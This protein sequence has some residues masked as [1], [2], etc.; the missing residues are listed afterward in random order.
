MEALTEQEYAPEPVADIRARNGFINVMGNLTLLTQA[1]NSTVSD[2]PFTVKV[3][4]VKA[5]SALALNRELG[6][7]DRRDESAIQ[8]RS[9]ALFE[10]ARDIWAPPQRADIADAGNNFVDE[11]LALS[12]RFPDACT[13]CRFTYF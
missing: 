8:K 6:V 3:S 7:F 9:E 5:N 4:A 1:L 12:T 11:S 10:V 2:G 13:K